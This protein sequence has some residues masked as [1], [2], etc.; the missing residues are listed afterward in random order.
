MLKTILALGAV[1][2]ADAMSFGARLE[3]RIE[4]HANAN[5][6]DN[7]D[8]V[9][10]FAVVGYDLDGEELVGDSRGNIT[11]SR[12]LRGGGRGSTAM[13]RGGGRGLAPQ[14][15]GG[16]GY[17]MQPRGGF[18]QGAMGY[19][20]PQGTQVPPWLRGGFGVHAPNEQLHVMPLVPQNSGNTG[21]FTSAVTSIEFIA[22]PQKP[23]RGERLISSVAPSSAA[24]AIPVSSGIFVGVDLQQVEAGNI[25]LATWAAT[26]FGVRLAMVDALPGIEIRMPCTLVG[27]MTAGDTIAVAL[28]V[29][30]RVLA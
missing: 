17:G 28:T 25:P 16:N 30:G 7:W 15:R 22:R 1:G 10:G 3:Q 13:T 6:C 11:H 29:L 14:G 12:N 4:S 24:V 9:D 27:T 18:G 19:P 2:A 5:V 21:I 26:A 20:F 23:F 8:G